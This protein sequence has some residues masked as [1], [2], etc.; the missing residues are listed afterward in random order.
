MFLYLSTVPLELFSTQSSVLSFSEHWFTCL[1][2]LPNSILG[3]TVF[4][5]F[6][7]FS[8]ELI[9]FTTNTP[10]HKSQFQHVRLLC[11]AWLVFGDWDWLITSIVRVDT[12]KE[13]KIIVGSIFVKIIIGL[14]LKSSTLYLSLTIKSFWFYGSPPQS[15]HH[16]K[17]HLM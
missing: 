17:D 13:D 15:M 1:I 9:S 6:S 8:T 16:I 4:G 12:R 5:L 7:P 14:S 2:R 11:L 3:S 10:V